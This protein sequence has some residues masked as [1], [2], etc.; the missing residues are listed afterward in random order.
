[1]RYYFACGINKQQQILR[2]YNPS[3]YFLFSF[4]FC[5][6][7]P[8]DIPVSNILMDSGG[9]SVRMHGGA[10]DIVEYAKFLNKYGVKLAFNLDTN[11]VKETVENF[12]FLVKECTGTYI[13]PIYHYSDYILNT[14]SLDAFQKY[15]YIALGGI[16]GVTMSRNN[17]RRFFDYAFSTYKNRI[18]GLGVSNVMMLQYYPFYSV[19]SS[20]W[21]SGFRFGNLKT[22]PKQLKNF[23]KEHHWELLLRQELAYYMRIEPTITNLW[24]QRGLVWDDNFYNNA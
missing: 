9:Y 23:S 11:D 7:L 14:V 5:L 15:P 19:D 8:D 13:I 12:N 18:H 21:G 3:A 20:T 22:I 10:I 17:Q 2:N 16:A 1:M 6:R 4:A 24:K